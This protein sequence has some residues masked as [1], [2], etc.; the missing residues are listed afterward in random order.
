MTLRPEHLT[1]ANCIYGESGPD[2]TSSKVVRNVPRRDFCDVLAHSLT[3][4]SHS[5]D[6]SPSTTLHPRSPPLHHLTLKQ[7]SASESQ[8]SST[9]AIRSLAHLLHLSALSHSKHEYLPTTSA[10]TTIRGKGPCVQ[11]RRSK[12]RHPPPRSTSAN[13]RAH[14]P[15]QLQGCWVEIED[16]KGRR[17]PTFISPPPSPLERPPTTTSARPQPLFPPY[18]YITLQRASHR[19]LSTKPPRHSPPQ[20][21]LPLALTS[22]PTSSA[23]LLP[24]AFDRC[25]REYERAERNNLA[26]MPP[27]PLTPHPSTRHPATLLRIPDAAD[28]PA[29][30]AQT[31]RHPP[32]LACRKTRT[33]PIRRRQL[34]A[35]FVGAVLVPISRSR[36][37]LPS[38]QHVPEQDPRTSAAGV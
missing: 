11:Y 35:A 38:R 20:V 1:L 24:P 4:L 28:S 18:I 21:R 29:H 3:S 34:N 30:D 10:T 26:A 5:N 15:H 32:S 16:F 31:R 8:D 19:R 2:S 12:T 33:T 27:P 22:P 14:L 6:I 23:S 25:S 37:A 36:C 9:P 7:S 13:E 17:R